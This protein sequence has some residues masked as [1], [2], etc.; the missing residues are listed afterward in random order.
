MPHLSSTS[1]SNTSAQRACKSARG[2]ECN[3]GSRLVEPETRALRALPDISFPERRRT[4]RLGSDV[5][6]TSIKTG[7][8]CTRASDS[9]LE[10]RYERESE[11]KESSH[12][13]A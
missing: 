6:S 4:L 11:L 12:S 10:V 9:L 3:P 8:R 1:S 13:A 2:K 7:K 5:F